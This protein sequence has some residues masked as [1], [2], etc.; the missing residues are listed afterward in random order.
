AIQDVIAELDA[1]IKAQSESGKLW[2]WKLDDDTYGINDPDINPIRHR[3]V[4]FYFYFY[5]T[6]NSGIT[7]SVTYFYYMAIFSEVYPMEVQLARNLLVDLCNDLRQIEGETST[8][9]DVI[10]LQ[11]YLKEYAKQQF[12]NK[13]GFDYDTGTPPDKKGKTALVFNSRSDN[14]VPFPPYARVPIYNNVTQHFNLY[15]GTDT[16]KDTNTWYTAHND[17]YL[18]DPNGERDSVHEYAVYVYALG[19]KSEGETK[20]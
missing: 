16:Q 19:K 13:F 6:T 9:T 18:D 15:L 12:K 14:Y 17:G 4:I 2:V 8:S 3:G 7:I 11:E 10:A 1:Y 20:V 5:D